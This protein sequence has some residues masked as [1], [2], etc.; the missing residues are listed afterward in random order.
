MSLY[1]LVKIDVIQWSNM[2]TLRRV[3]EL[4]NITHLPFARL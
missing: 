1:N 4:R 3:M 2:N